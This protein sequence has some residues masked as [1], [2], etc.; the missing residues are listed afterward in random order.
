MK[1]NFVEKYSIT[2]PGLM[3]E[4]TKFGW[5]YDRN[6]CAGDPVVFGEFVATGMSPHGEKFAFAGT[7]KVLRNLCRKARTVDQVLNARRFVIQPSRS[8]VLSMS[9]FG[10]DADHDYRDL[11]WSGAPE[12]APR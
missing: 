8:A 7:G 12:R 10:H 11:A 1:T 5:W 6:F 4:S 3:I 2:C 9:A